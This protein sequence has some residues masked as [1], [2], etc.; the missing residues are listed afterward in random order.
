[1]RISPKIITSLRFVSLQF[2]SIHFTSLNFTPIFH[3]PTLLEVSSPRFK[4]S[5][6]LLINNYFPSLL[7]KDIS[8]ASAG[9]WFLSLVVLFTNQYLPISVLC[10]LAL[11]LLS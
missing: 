6:L 5:S 3:F 1:M 2:N 10:F 7:S 8:C 9:S 11:I 4:N